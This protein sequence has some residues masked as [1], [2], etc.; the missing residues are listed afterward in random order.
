MIFYYSGCGNS[1]FVAEQIAA[2]TNEELLFIPD[3]QREGMSEYAISQGES[4]GFVFPVYAWG[5][6]KLVEDFVKTVQWKGES[7]YVWFAC[8]CGDEM[9]YTHRDFKQ[10][11][12]EAGLELKGTFCFQMPETYLCFPGFHL[13]TKENA[14]KK[15]SA[16]R[17]KLPSVIEHIKT[18]AEV[19]DQI[20]GSTPGLKSNVIRPGFIKFMSD[21][22]YHTTEDCNGCGLCAKKCPLHNI[23]ME[24]GHPAW[25]GHCTQCMACYHYCPK[26]AIQYGTY[27]KD[28]GQYHF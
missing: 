21:K 10:T 9:G 5:A 24:D 20:L 13:D 23:K 19:V 3:L 27:T 11:L 8:T 16:V 26:N 28:K 18:R 1:R 2:G 17:A 25:Q 14:D 22:K 7:A 15:I 6:P 12:H 4:I